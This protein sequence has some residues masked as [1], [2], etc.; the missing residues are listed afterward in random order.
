MVTRNLSGN[1][2]FQ[3]LATFLSLVSLLSVLAWVIKTDQK[4]TE[5]QVKENKL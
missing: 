4:P 1:D 2:A 5:G 3:L